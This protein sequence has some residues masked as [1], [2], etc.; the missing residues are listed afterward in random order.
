MS[1]WKRV[2]NIMAKPEPL[3]PEKE[4]ITLG[5]GDICEISLVSYQ[6]IGRTD[7]RL[8][9]SAWLTLRDGSDIRYLLVEQREQPYYSLYDSIDGRLDSVEEVPTEIELDGKWFYMEDQYNGNV[10]CT[11]QTPFRVSGEQYVWH[12]QSDDRKLL[13]VEWQD[14]RFQLYEGESVISADVRILRGT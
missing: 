10:V 1:L 9:N 3:Q 12:Y 7:W 8:R 5:P 14:G 13:R 6:A 2:K 4:P 11:G